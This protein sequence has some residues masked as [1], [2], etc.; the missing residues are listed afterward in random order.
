M[1]LRTDRAMGIKTEGRGA[2]VWIGIGPG[3]QDYL[4]REL[5]ALTLYGKGRQLGTPHIT[6]LCS[7]FDSL[8]TCRE[9]EDAQRRVRGS[10]IPDPV[11]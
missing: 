11:C 8:M 10:R 7:C 5:W 3:K 4:R 1:R 6:S 9:R 2:L